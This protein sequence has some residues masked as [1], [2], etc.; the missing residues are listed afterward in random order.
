LSS[1]RV[2]DPQKDGR[3]PGYLE[4]CAETKKVVTEAPVSG[5]IAGPWTI[6]MG[7]RGATNLIIDTKKDAAFVHELMKITTEA[8]RKFTEALSG[9]GIGVGYSE[10]PASCDLISP[11][12]YREFILPYHKE[13]ITYF[14]QKKVGV[15]LHVCGNANPILEDL[16][17]TG[18]SNMSVDSKTNLDKASEVFSKKAVLIGNV[19]TDCFLAN[20]KEVMRN[21]IRDCLEK[22]PKNSGYI[23]APGCEVPTI[24]PPE[25]I[26]WFMELAR[27]VGS[28][29][30]GS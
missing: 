12:L 25:K 2:P 17:S 11:A 14:N 30:A 21:A 16:A 27:E 15:G 6:A 8:T 7:L 3:L 13:L 18:L 19:P 5:V 26:D 1:L 24:A 23:L 20:S 22:A 28:Y 29:Q 9:I 10:A 4:A